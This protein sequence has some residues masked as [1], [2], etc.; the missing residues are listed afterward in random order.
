MCAFLFNAQEWT[1]HLHMHQQLSITSNKK[2]ETGQDKLHFDKYSDTKGIPTVIRTQ[3]Q[4]WLLWRFFYVFK[5]FLNISPLCWL[6]GIEME[7]EG[8]RGGEKASSS[9]NNKHQDVMAA[10]FATNRPQCIG[11]LTFLIVCSRTSRPLT[12]NQ[13]GGGS[14]SLPRQR[15]LKKEALPGT[16]TLR[17]AVALTLHPL[18]QN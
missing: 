6:G 8:G 5:L 18:V 13:G 9:N 4:M 11:F 3:Q 10:I 2:K 16:Q 1:G 14:G 17:V 15:K 7:R 12:G